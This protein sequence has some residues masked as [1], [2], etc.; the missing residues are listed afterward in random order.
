MNKEISWPHEKIIDWLIDVDMLWDEINQDG[1]S[2]GRLQLRFLIDQLKK[3]I[4]I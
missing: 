2:E 4:N 3:E 1:E